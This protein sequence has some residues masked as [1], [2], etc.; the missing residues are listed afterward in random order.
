MVYKAVQLL[1]F[2]FA[3]N[4]FSQDYSVLWEGH[5]S[6]YNI[7]DVVQGNDKIYAAS[8]NA[9]FIY[10]ESNQELETVT[11]VEGLSGDVISTIAYSEIYDLLLVG[12]EN[13]LIEVVQGSEH[14]ILTVVDILE[15]E[16]ISPTLKRINDFYEYEGLVYISTD[17]GIS[18]YDLEYLEFGDTYFIGN[19]GAQITVNQVSVHEGYI[20][21]ACSSSM[22]IK[23]AE[24]SNPNLIDY[25]QWQTVVGGNYIGIS[26]VNEN[27]YT[28][29]SNKT[30]YEIEQTTLNQLYTY[31]DIPLD[32]KSVGEFLVVITKKD[33]FVY[34]ANFILTSNANVTGIYTT[35]FSA[36]TVSNNHI[37]IGTDSLGLLQTELNSPANYFEI[38]PGG[39]LR[40]SAFK[41]QAG[42]NNLWVTFGGFTVD[43]APSPSILYGISHLKGE[44]WINTSKDSVFGARNLNYIAVNPFKLSQ[45][46]I[47]SFQNGI[48]QIENELPTILLD[49]T[50]SGL[51]S[52]VIPGNP[53]YFSIRQSGSQF[54]RNGILWTMTGRV[55]SPLKSYNPSTGDWNSYSFNEIIPDGFSGEWGYSDLVI[56]NNGTKW[57]GGYHNGVMGYNEN[58]N[59]INR[60]YNL[61]QNMP[62]SV[63]RALAM[64]NRNQL[65]IGT[66]K[67]L[68]VLYNTANFL[69]NPNPTVNEIVILEDDIPQEL[70]ADQFITDIKVDGSNNKWIG[71]LTS[72]VFYFSP[73][74]QETIYH[75]TKSNSPLPSDAINDISIDSENGRV[76]FATDKGLVSFLAGGSKTEDELENA[77]VY[78]NP[79]RPEYNVLGFDDLNNI[80]KGVK[81]KGLT[82]NVNIKITDIE[83]N[84]VAEAQSRV[85]QRTSRAGYNFAIDGGTAIWNGKNLANNVVATGVYLIMISDLD[86]FET[87]VLKLLIVR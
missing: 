34:D 12:Y 87:K 20:Y 67:G 18:I 29:R 81:I 4:C 46:F 76:Y 68:R 26:S 9:I 82:E 52:L 54:D 80:T 45:V 39:P 36:A 64:D 79:V 74:G 48:L 84:L 33:V 1:V 66:I 22:G 47:S 38:R 8:E 30:I 32:M 56:D 14:E 21:A 86:S 65:W 24:L 10:D 3:I 49:N 27:L 31:T 69:D 28:I 42:N 61:E 63:V 40:N 75:F 55:D 35:N 7:K 70:L 5:F 57:T 72:G 73:D 37:Y 53:D 62:S 15:K 19:G 6:Y 51:E 83:G 71:T 50:N 85:N 77:F 41:I 13:G 59:S 16:T 2:L 60:V 17:Y 58:G 11:T 78:P 43:Y 23:R 25:Q 44:E